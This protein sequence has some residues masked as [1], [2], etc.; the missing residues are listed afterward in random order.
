MPSTFIIDGERIDI[1]I[2]MRHTLWA[3]GSD[4]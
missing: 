3:E 4:D 2:V 1:V